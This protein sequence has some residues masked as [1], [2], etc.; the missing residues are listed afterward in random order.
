MVERGG[1]AS[2]PGIG[3]VGAVPLVD[4]LPRYYVDS[5]LPGYFGGDGDA[6]DEAERIRA[7]AA[8]AGESSVLP[9][10]AE[11]EAAVRAGRDPHDAQH[12]QPR[13]DEAGPVGAAQPAY[14]PAAHLS[15]QTASDLPRPAAP[16]RSNTARSA[17]LLSAFRCAPS[18]NPEPPLPAAPPR[19][20]DT[21]DAPHASSSTSSLDEAHHHH[22]MGG[23]HRTASSS[24]VSL[25]SASTKLDGASVRKGK[26][27]AAGEEEDGAGA[28]ASS[29]RVKL[30][31][32][33]A[34]DVEKPSGRKD[35]D[36]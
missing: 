5:G 23:L 29:S 20:S 7:E 3:G 21:A 32:E 22:G 4:E 16:A 18:P 36:A 31:D 17:L 12:Q 33:G 6:A 26:Q 24:S 19:G 27:A 34:G 1:G 2:T 13:Q 9:S 8:A 10:A 28:D 15:P 11:Y 14:P 30:D 25:S 35:G